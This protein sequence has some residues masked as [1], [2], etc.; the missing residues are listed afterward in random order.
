MSQ[1]EVHDESGELKLLMSEA[2][3]SVDDLAIAQ[4]AAAAMESLSPESAKML[5]ERYGLDFAN[6]VG[7]AFG[8][9]I[10]SLESL[11]QTFGSAER[12]FVQVQ[13]QVDSLSLSASKFEK[14]INAGGSNITVR[15]FV[16]NGVAKISTIFK[17]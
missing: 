15:G 6:K 11:A 7:H 4:R 5:A 16:Q 1:A 9:D 2:V 3:L 17:P 10:H 12:A 14:I 13:S 8:K